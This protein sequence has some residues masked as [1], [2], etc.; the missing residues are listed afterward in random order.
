[1]CRRLKIAKKR[2]CDTI[3]SIGSRTGRLITSLRKEVRVM[4]F[5]F[6]IIILIILWKMFTDNDKK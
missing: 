5:I 3:K 2:L 6:L 1:M 4:E